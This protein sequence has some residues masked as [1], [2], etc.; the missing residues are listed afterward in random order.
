MKFNH[1]LIIAVAL[2]ASQAVT[3]ANYDSSNRP[4]N[5]PQGYTQDG[6]MTSYP[7]ENQGYYQNPQRQNYPRA[8]GQGYYGQDQRTYQGQSSQ[9]YMQDQRY[10]RSQDQGYDR[11]LPPLS[12]SDRDLLNRIRQV[13]ESNRD[14]RFSNINIRISN[15]NVIITGF[16]ESDEARQNIK[17]RIRNIEGVRNIEDRLEIRQMRNRMDTDRSDY[18]SDNKKPADDSDSQLK[19]KIR[20]KFKGGFFSRGYDNVQFQVNNGKVTLT[21]TVEKDSDRNDLSEKVNKIEGVKSIDNQ[22]T[23]RR[24]TNAAAN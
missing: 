10:D 4:M 15:G 16:I 6:Q 24:N 2:T 20:D 9:G 17:N 19:E 11:N 5:Q 1:S 8:Q 12:Q 22:V 7:Q 18:S 13:I 14:S 23:V 21:G 3:A